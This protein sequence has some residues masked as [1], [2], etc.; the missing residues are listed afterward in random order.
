MN[1]ITMLGF[2][3]G[4]FIGYFGSLVV[5]SRTVREIGIQVSE[6]KVPKS[7]P[8]SIQSSPKRFIPELK[9]F[10]GSDP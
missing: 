9:N 3:V 8:I 4:V 6:V 2:V 5:K 10:W 1:S 7:H